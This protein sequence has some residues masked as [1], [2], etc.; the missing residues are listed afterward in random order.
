M[1]GCGLGLGLVLGS[2]GWVP[3]DLRELRVDVLEDV[4][5]VARVGGRLEPREDLEAL[6]QVVQHVRLFGEIL[7][8]FERK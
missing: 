6:Q 7:V 5:G 2:A 8:N 4:A 1:L 3:S